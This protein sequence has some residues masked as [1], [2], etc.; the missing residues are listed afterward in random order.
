[1]RK[2][3]YC[4]HSKTG[5]YFLVRNTNSLCKFMQIRCMISTIIVCRNLTVGHNSEFSFDILTNHVKLE[6]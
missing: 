2:N 5:V 3:G 6:I 4:I 1:M